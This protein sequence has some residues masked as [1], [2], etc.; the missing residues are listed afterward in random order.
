MRHQIRSLPSV[1][2]EFSD[3][4]DATNSLLLFPILL[5]FLLEVVSCE[6]GRRLKIR[7]LPSVNEEFSDKPDATDGRLSQEIYRFL[8]FSTTNGTIISSIEIP[9]C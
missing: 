6:A 3:K 2:E 4:P 1:N 8:G 7:S 9:P 5:N